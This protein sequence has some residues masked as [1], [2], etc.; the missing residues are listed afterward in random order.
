MNLRITSGKL[1]ESGK[2]LE[3]DLWVR[4]HSKDTPLKWL[5]ER[6]DCTGWIKWHE[7]DNNLE[8]SWTDWEW[9]H[10]SS[11]ISWALRIRIERG[12][13]LRGAP[14]CE[15]IWHEERSM[16]NTA[17][18]NWIHGRRKETK[19]NKL[20]APLVS[21]WE[22]PDKNIERNEWRDFSQIKGIHD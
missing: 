6:G 4:A 3:K 16:I 20:V 17:S 9:K 14:T 21:S 11:E 19:N 8:I 12:E 22:S 5:I 2:I 18:L 15:I 1:G 13:Q 10:K 7:W